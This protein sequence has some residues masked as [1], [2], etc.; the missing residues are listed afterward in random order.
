MAEPTPVDGLVSGII[1]AVQKKIYKFHACNVHSINRLKTK[2][3]IIYYL[4]NY[5]TEVPEPVPPAILWSSTNPPKR[6]HFSI[7]V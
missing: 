6:S 3:W 4:Y 2:T 1:I 7:S 5:S